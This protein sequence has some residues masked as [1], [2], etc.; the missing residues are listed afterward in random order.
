MSITACFKGLWNPKRDLRT[1]GRG[2]EATIL[3]CGRKAGKDM[4]KCDAG[5][6]QVS[7]GDLGN[8]GFGSCLRKEAGGSLEYEI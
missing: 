7:L 3:L 8:G 6:I 1:V 2:D 5:I 4:P